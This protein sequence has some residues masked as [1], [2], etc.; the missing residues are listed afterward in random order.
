MTEVPKAYFTTVKNV[1]G[2][3][4]EYYSNLLQITERN[5]GMIFDLDTTPIQE[6]D[7]IENIDQLQPLDT[8]VN[9]GFIMSS[10]RTGN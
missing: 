10:S 4:M 6:V 8:M 9:T 7:V 1:N 2:L 3:D 5:N